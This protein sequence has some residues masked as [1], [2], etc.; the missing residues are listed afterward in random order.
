MADVIVEPQFEQALVSA[1]TSFGVQLSGA[2]IELMWQHFCLVRETNEKFNLTR[3]TDVPRAAVEHYADSLTLLPWLVAREVTPRRAIDV[4]TGGGWPA[5][6]LA[7]ALP[8]VKWTAVDSTGKKARFVAETAAS[9]GLKNLA[10]R[11]ARANELAGKVP[12]FDLVVCRAVGRVA[13][14]IAETAR[15]LTPGGHLV[16]YK[17]A[18]I[19]AE[20][21]NEGD[22]AA[23]RAKLTP[24][25]EFPVAMKG[26][27][28]MYHRI[29]VSYQRGT[30][31]DVSRD[32]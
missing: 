13:D 3:I 20:E 21:R 14:L 17:T 4:G 9:L 5:V 6:P 2:Q 31:R 7:I 30:P 29:L 19:P 11:Q 27:E 26:G 1:C 8:E 23:S 18:E 24:E 16:C 15:L 25:P 28:A 32:C 22:R 12:P 10:V